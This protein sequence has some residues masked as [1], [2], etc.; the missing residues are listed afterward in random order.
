MKDTK[1]QIQ[2]QK[3]PNAVTLS[4]NSNWASGTQVADDEGHQPSM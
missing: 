2:G 3:R 4:I 1:S